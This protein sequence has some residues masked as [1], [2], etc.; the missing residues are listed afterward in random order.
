MVACPQGPRWTGRE[1]SLG[2]GV[3]V[4]GYGDK[5]SG[6]HC[7]PDMWSAILYMT[8][9]VIHVEVIP[10]PVPALQYRGLTGHWGAEQGWE[11]MCIP[12]P[13][14]PLVSVS[15]LGGRDNWATDGGDCENSR[16]RP[17]HLSYCWLSPEQASHHSGPH[18]ASQCGGQVRPTGQHLW[19]MQ[20]GRP[21]FSWTSFHFYPARSGAL[22]AGDHILSI[23]GTSTERCSL[24]DA[25]KLLAGVVEKVR[26]EVLPAPQ[27]RWP[28]QPVD[29]GGSRAW[30]KRQRGHATCPSRVASLGFLT[31]RT[32]HLICRGMLLAV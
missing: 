8:E 4:V 13:H 29:A 31:S 23:D 12:F 24:Q 11:E 17:G 2:L 19:G 20:G 6:C 9:T 22:R 26:L 15:R 14:N 25:T 5:G 7:Q 30:T 10:V 16:V 1:S 21:S 3:Q 28:P 27:S 18:Q 32:R